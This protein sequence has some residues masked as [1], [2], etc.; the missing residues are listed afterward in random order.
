[1]RYEALK[2]DEILKGIKG[3]IFS[4]IILLDEIDSTNNFAKKLVSEGV[5]EGTIIIAESQ[6]AGKG[7]M[8]RSWFSKKYANLLFSLL[9]RPN[10]GKEYIFSLSMGLALSSIEAIEKIVGIHAMIKWPNDIYVA[11]KKLAGILSEFSIK[12]KTLEYVILGMGINVNWHP[13][14]K[15]FLYPATSLFKE[16]GEYIKREPLLSE[17]LQ[18]FDRYYKDILN[19]DID[20]LYDMWNKRS[21]IIGRE[22]SV[23]GYEKELKGRVIRIERDGSLILKVNGKEERVLYGDV[24]LR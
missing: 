4:N 14:N 11:D 5:K 16:K 20:R 1:M 2:R 3:T 19:E 23:M 22:V 8:G 12:G 13:E 6:T 17:I 18:R 7:R 10:L 15:E 9:L 21:M 24:S